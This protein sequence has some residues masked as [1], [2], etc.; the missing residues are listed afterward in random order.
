M[1]S[2]KTNSERNCVINGAS[3][4]GAGSITYADNGLTQ[5]EMCFYCRQKAIKS[6]PY[7]KISSYCSDEHG[8]IHR[9]N[10][11][12]FP[13]RIEYS[14]NVGNYM[15]ATRDIAPTGMSVV[16]FIIQSTNLR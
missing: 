3:D 6:C 14:T 13:F 15:I 11:V 9:P 2:E 8:I 12:C 16:G 4:R 10:D 1:D 7:C 5:G